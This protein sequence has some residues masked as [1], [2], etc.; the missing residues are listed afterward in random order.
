MQKRSQWREYE[1]QPWLST[2]WLST[3]M[4]CDVDTHDAL[5]QVDAILNKYL[6][7]SSKRSYTGFVR[8]DISMRMFMSKLPGSVKEYHGVPLWYLSHGGDISL[9]LILHF[10]RKLYK[11]NV[12]YSVLQKANDCLPFLCDEII[13]HQFSKDVEFCFL[14]T[15]KIWRFHRS[16]T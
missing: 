2:T 11:R 16:M 5:D 12:I 15:N 13:R 1:P 9:T 14:A 10:Q 8:S 6:R 4:P 7:S 3:T